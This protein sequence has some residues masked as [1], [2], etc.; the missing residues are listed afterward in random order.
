MSTLPNLTE[1]ELGLLHTYS[2]YTNTGRNI[3]DRYSGP[4]DY[5]KPSKIITDSRGAT[6]ETSPLIGKWRAPTN[7]SRHVS[8]SE[9]CSGVYVTHDRV[10]AEDTKFTSSHREGVVQSQVVNFP[11]FPAPEYATENDISRAETEALARVRKLEVQ[12]GVAI[13]EAARSVNQISKLA[14][15]AYLAMKDV[16]SGNFYSAGRRLGIYK[17]ASNN[18]KSASQWWLA[19]NY[20]LKPT[21]LDIN[22]A[23]TDIRNGLA[24]AGSHVTAIRNIK[25]NYRNNVTGEYI[26]TLLPYGLRQFGYNGVKVR[27]DYRMSSAYV[28]AVADSGVLRFDEIAYELVP[29]SFVL[30]W[31]LPIGTTLAALGAGAGLD[32]IGGTKTTYYKSTAKLRCEKSL[33]YE[34][35]LV[36]GRRYGDV[37]FSGSEVKQGM[38]RGVYNTAPGPS[39][40]M[41]NPLSVSHATSALALLITGFQG[42]H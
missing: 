3:T 7:Y 24:E 23:V 31:F 28:N 11:G 4:W 34:R 5:D 19:Y 8:I 6:H 33:S 1:T 2:L 42:W 32:F 16:K 35:S 13:A 30:D 41:K 17:K 26:D 9:P 22:G 20:G 36:T 39:L 18:I 21:F 27:L 29:Y 25:H 14:S 12:Y 10:S 38:S 37:S 15:N 40:Y